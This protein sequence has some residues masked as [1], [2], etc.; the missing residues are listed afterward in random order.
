MTTLVYLGTFLGSLLLGLLLTRRVRDLALARGWVTAPHSTRHVHTTPMPRCGGVA[1]YIAVFIT[2][3]TVVLAAHYLHFNK[4]FSGRITAYILGGG[5]MVFLLGLYDDIF[6]ASVFA[7]F[8]V[9]IAAAVVLFSGG[10]RIGNL[11]SGWIGNHE[12]GWFFSLAA[13]ILW[14]VWITNSFN[15]IDGLDGLAA[16]SALFS[17]VT[18]LLMSLI[19]HHHLLAVLT[20]AVTGAILGFLRYNFN[21]AT[22]FLGDSGSLFVGFTLSALSLVGM[23]KTTTIVAVAIPIVAFGL[24]ATETALSVVRRFVTGQPLFKSDRAHIHHKLLEKGFSHT[25]VVVLLYG[26]SACFGLTSLYLFY[27]NAAFLVFFVAILGIVVGVRQLG[28]GEFV[29][30]GRIAQRAVTQKIIVNNL[31]IRDAVMGLQRATTLDQICEALKEAF[32]ENEFDGF[33]LRVDSGDGVP[34]HTSNFLMANHAGHL[35]YTWRKS[36]SNDRLEEAAATWSMQ[37]GLVSPDGREWGSLT[38]YR[39]YR[40]EPLLLDIDL[41]ISEFQTQLA[42]SVSQACTRSGSK[43][44]PPLQVSAKAA[45]HE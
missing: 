41:L 26:I 30:V 28:Y 21:P 36:T 2:V 35:L 6:G 3:S 25:Q 7:K 34:A 5:G 1:V 4:E 14:V 12:L 43:I 45:G 33:E 39:L 27:A 17:T 24:P 38:L 10:L 22:I 15:L 9:Q 16:G 13:T 29:E 32:F 11:L 23:Q 44:M 37:L 8:A 31:L 40:E 20:I 18:I 42:E 19:N